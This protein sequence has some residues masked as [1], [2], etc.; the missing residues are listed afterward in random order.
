MF[1]IDNMIWFLIILASFVVALSVFVQVSLRRDKNRHKGP[2][3]PIPPAPS[4]YGSNHEAPGE[5][6]PPTP[7]PNPPLTDI[8]K[9]TL[10]GPLPTSNQPPSD[11]ARIADALEKIAENTERRPWTGGVR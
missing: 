2:P 5:R 10:A 8:G 1:G 9:I 6:P 3:N 4:R 11:L 7:S